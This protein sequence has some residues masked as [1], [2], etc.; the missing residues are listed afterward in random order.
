MKDN[1]CLTL[2]GELWSVFMKIL[3]NETHVITYEEVL[4]QPYLYQ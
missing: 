2:T 1:P 3:D 4:F